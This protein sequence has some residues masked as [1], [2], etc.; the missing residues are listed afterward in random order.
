MLLEVL[1][2]MHVERAHDKKGDGDPDENKVLHISELF[3][4]SGA[5]FAEAHIK[6]ARD[7]KNPDADSCYD[8]CVHKL[9]P[10]S[11]NFRR[12]VS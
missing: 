6:R 12:S 7:E 3:L 1:A 11:A 10:A 2:K 8:E 5:S 9:A 4:L